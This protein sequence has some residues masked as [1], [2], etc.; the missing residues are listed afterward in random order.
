MALELSFMSHASW[1]HVSWIVPVTMSRQPLWARSQIV[2]L[3]SG[4]KR[5]ESILGSTCSWFPS[6][7]TTLIMTAI[8][9]QGIAAH[10]TETLMLTESICFEKFQMCGPHVPGVAADNRQ[11][12][13]PRPGP[14][15]IVRILL[16]AL[17]CSPARI[18]KLSSIS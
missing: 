6:G 5:K 1:D 8:L 10:S 17:I 14:S 12:R 13:S 11:G 7:M 16:I 2:F 3:V 9:S 15:A 4:F 18:S